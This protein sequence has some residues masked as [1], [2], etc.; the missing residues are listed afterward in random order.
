MSR[1]IAVETHKGNNFLTPGQINLPFYIVDAGTN[2]FQKDVSYSCDG[3]FKDFVEIMWCSAGCGELIL[4]DKR[5]T[6]SENDTFYYLPQEDH[7][8]HSLSD[9]WTLYW[10]CFGGILAE[11]IM[12]SYKYPRCQHAAEPLPK[13]LFEEFFYRKESADPT[14]NAM[15]CSKILE[16]IAKMSASHSKRLHPDQEVNRVMNFVK[17]NISNPEL[18]LDYA[19]VSL[20]ISKSTLQKHF[21]QH[22]KIALGEYIRN[23][24]F[25]RAISLL[26]NTNT[27]IKEIAREVGYTILPSFSRLIHRGTGKSPQELRKENS[28]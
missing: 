4:Q 18:S 28:R 3:M 23:E 11:A 15:I 8:F 16:L 6:V 7:E 25:Q 10:V 27:P 26:Q 14:A 22:T 19:A 1:K 13:A 12:C 2:I 17:S 9:G 5:W 21:F 20:G 24:R